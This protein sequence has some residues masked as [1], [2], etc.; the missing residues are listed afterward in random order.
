MQPL[1]WLGFL[2]LLLVIEA[3][4]AGLTTIWFAEAH[5]S[6]LLRVMQGRT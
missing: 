6:Q 3:I 2:A 1:I 5:W 4:T